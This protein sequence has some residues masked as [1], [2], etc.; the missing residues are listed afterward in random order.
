MTVSIPESVTAKANVK[1]IF[2]PTL[3]T[4]S[5]ATINAGVDISNFLM[6]G[7]DGPAGTQNTGRSG[8][9]GTAQTFERGGE[10][11]WS[12]AALEYTYLPQELGTPGHAANKVYEAL[13]AGNTGFIV[14]GYGI[15]PADAFATADVATKVPVECLVQSPKSRADDEFGPL[16]VLQSLAVNGVVEQDLVL[17]A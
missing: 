1:A 3:A 6:P 9:F 10:I 13:A 15:K 4:M 2:V 11:N 14:I 16:T 17:V 7:W 12:I 5:A 8:R